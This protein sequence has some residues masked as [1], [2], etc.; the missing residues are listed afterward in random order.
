MESKHKMVFQY[1]QHFHVL[2]SACQLVLKDSI[3]KQQ[4]VRLNHKVSSF[5]HMTQFKTT[6]TWYSQTT[7]KVL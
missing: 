2:F 4:T 6:M 5:A 1:F 3:F 7:E